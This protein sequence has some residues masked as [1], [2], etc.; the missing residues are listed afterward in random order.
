MAGGV[1]AWVCITAVIAGCLAAGVTAQGS[2]TETS[3]S[4]DGN[5]GVSVTTGNDGSSVSTTSVARGGHSA[6]ASATST[7]SSDGEGQRT[8]GGGSTSV[9]GEPGVDLSV[10]TEPADPPAPSPQ[11]SIPP[12]PSSRKPS[13]SSGPVSAS[14]S[15]T[16]TGSSSASA[17]ASTTGSQSDDEV[18]KPSRPPPP[19]EVP[20][21]PAPIVVPTKPEAE[22]MVSSFV[23]IKAGSGSRTRTSATPSKDD[24][25]DKK[26]SGAKD[27]ELCAGLQ[28][29]HAC[30]IQDFV[31]NENGTFS[32]CT[33]SFKRGSQGFCRYRMVSDSPRVWEDIGPFVY[34]RGARCKCASRDPEPCTGSMKSECCEHHQGA[35]DRCGCFFAGSLNERC[36]WKKF[37]DKPLIWED[38]MIVLGRKCTCP[39]A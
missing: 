19:K 4:D 21:S 29:Y 15:A 28:E 2:F 18:P 25:D 32:G 35:S 14:A 5:Q 11:E 26:A 16:S 13:P 17:S 12:K 10:S 20:S 9:D 7:V 31:T 8:F 34:R 3:T 22:K 37:S 39:S 27:I 38:A 30:K 33:M 6:S 1:A 24:E 36:L 23:E